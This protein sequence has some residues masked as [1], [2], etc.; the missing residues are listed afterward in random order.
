MSNFR[1]LV[2]LLLV[3]CSTTPEDPDPHREFNED[4]LDFNLTVD[5]NI[6]KPVSSV[7]KDVTA[8]PVRQMVSNFLDNWKEP[9]YF[10]NYTLCGEGENMATSL[11]RFVINSTVGLLGLFDIAEEIDLDKTSTNYKETFKKLEMPHGDYIV[12]PIFGSS[13]TRDAI[14]EPISWFADPVSYFIGWPW[15]LAKAV[16]GAVSNRAENAEIIDSTIKDSMDIYSTTRSL[17]LQ[18]YGVGERTNSFGDDSDFEEDDNDSKDDQPENN[19]NNEEQ[20]TNEKDKQ[21][22]ASRKRDNDVC[23]K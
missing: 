12:L 16:V 15:M 21:K 5:E 11:F 18:K 23:K 9:F 8:N 10:V 3:G 1:V 17:Y 19:E 4:M 13:S 22:T 6:L 14:A 7:Y 2:L 20:Q